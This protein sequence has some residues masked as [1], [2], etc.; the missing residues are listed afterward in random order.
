MIR[1]GVWQLENWARKSK[2]V[3]LM[4]QQ[5]V[6]SEVFHW[7]YLKFVKFLPIPKQDSHVIYI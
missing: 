4:K 7:R 2:M 6:E 1:S 3:L 5:F